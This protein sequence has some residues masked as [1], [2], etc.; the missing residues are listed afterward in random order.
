MYRQPQ[1]RN[2]TN[3]A[4]TRLA[5]QKTDLSET[6]YIVLLY[7]GGAHVLVQLLLVT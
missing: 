1:T 2:F 7:S 6:H 4:I 5:A 3:Y